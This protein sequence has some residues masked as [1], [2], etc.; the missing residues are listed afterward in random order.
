MRR[1]WPVPAA[2]LLT[3]CAFIFVTADVREVPL[4][5]RLPDA[6][7]DSVQL[8]NASV[9]YRFMPLD[10]SREM[11]VKSPSGHF[12]V[13]HFNAA[14]DSLCANLMQQK[15]GDVSDTA[16]Q[17]I[18]VEVITA[19][20]HLDDYN[21]Y[22]PDFRYTVGFIVELRL[23]D[24]SGDYVKNIVYHDEVAVH[25]QAETIPKLS[26]LVNG[27]LLQFVRNIDATLDERQEF[28]P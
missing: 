25:N 22:L 9:S 20:Q 8:I 19:L 12:Y 15:F 26:A 2:L 1:A 3:G 16:T 17:N 21:L 14:L 28:H 10:E 7:A 27:L 5:T 4:L 18:E 24:E 6:V 11:S 13:Y 23:S